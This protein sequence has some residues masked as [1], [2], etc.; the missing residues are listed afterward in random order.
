[1]SVRT[2]KNSGFKL[3]T[4]KTDVRKCQLCELLVATPVICLIHLSQ[5]VPASSKLWSF[6]SKSA[7]F[8]AKDTPTL[9]LFFLTCSEINQT[10]LYSESIIALLAFNHQFSLQCL[11][12]D[13]KTV[14]FPCLLFCVVLKNLKPVHHGGTSLDLASES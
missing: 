5:S 9:L 6:Q 13:S 3:Q 7:L 12:K 14:L 2:M 1:M 11:E 8:M 10:P 4:L